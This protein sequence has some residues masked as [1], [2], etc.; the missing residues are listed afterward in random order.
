MRRRFH[1]QWRLVPAYAIGL[2]GSTF[3]HGLRFM[4]SA[5]DRLM[6]VAKQP[7]A[8]WA[9]WA[10]ATNGPWWVTPQPVVLGR[11]GRWM[12]SCGKAGVTGRGFIQQDFGFV[13]FAHQD[14]R[15]VQKFI[16]GFMACRRLAGR[17][18]ANGPPAMR[19]PVSGMQGCVNDLTFLG[20]GIGH[21]DGTTLRMA[22][23]VTR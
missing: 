15:E 10:D 19:D 7:E 22:S 3:R 2:F 11:D 4:K 23:A 13:T 16:D 20:A 8:M 21:P 18:F 9:F 14:K 12:R 17:F 1:R 5:S 6:K